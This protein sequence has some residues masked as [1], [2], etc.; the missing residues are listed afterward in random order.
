MFSL[1]ISGRD[2]AGSSPS[3]NN[4]R[5]VIGELDLFSSKKT[6]DNYDHSVNYPVMDSSVD[7]AM[8][9]ERSRSEAQLDVNVSV[10]YVRPLFIS[11]ACGFFF[12][13]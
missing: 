10:D 6:N 4:P 5:V 2:S 3:A 1:N 11:A 8:K 7:V 12:S 9:H 13:F